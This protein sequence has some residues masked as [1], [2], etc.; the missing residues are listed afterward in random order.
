[1]MQGRKKQICSEVTIK[2]QER[3]FEMIVD[4]AIKTSTQYH[5]K[6]KFGVVIK[7]RENR[8]ENIHCTMGKKA[9]N[10]HP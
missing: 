5:L 8:L 2:R 7:G 3:C 9:K 1:M 10:M 4:N 6:K